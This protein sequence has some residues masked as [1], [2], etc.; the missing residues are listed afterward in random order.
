MKI[1][2]I[3]HY[4]VNPPLSGGQIRIYNLNRNLARYCKI[5]QFSFTPA[6]RRKTT[7]K[8]KNYN[9]H[10]IPVPIYI[11]FTFFIYRVL[12]IPFDFIAK[13]PIRR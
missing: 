4:Y 1:V 2:N 12:K 13:V 5:E 8:N 10:I 7:I 3:S 9:E 11:F 6:L